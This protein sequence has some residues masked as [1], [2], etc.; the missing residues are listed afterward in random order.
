MR[1]TTASHYRA[2]VYT[3]DLSSDPGFGF[4]GWRR[5]YP[6]SYDGEGNQV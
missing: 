1:Y 4:E 2:R 6:R 5:P 3:V